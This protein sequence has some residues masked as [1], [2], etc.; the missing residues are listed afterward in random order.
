[1]VF[2]F[3]FTKALDVNPTGEEPAPNLPLSLTRNT[4]SPYVRL[5]GQADRKE[6]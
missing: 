1:M 2:G 6:S 4:V 3:Q 5:M